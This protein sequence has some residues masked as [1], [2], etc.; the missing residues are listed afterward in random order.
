M[1]GRSCRNSLRIPSTSGRE[2][3]R[4]GAEGQRHSLC[5]FSLGCALAVTR[6]ARSAGSEP[7]AAGRPGAQRRP[8]IPVGNPCPPP[9]LPPASPAPTTRSR[10]AAAAP[11][12]EHSSA[13]ERSGSWRDGSNS[14]GVM[15]R[16]SPARSPASWCPRGGDTRLGDSAPKGRSSWRPR[17]VPTWEL[18]PL[19]W[20]VPRRTVTGRPVGNS[21]FPSPQSTVVQR[22][23]PLRKSCPSR[24]EA[25]AF[26]ALRQGYDALAL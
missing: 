9:R 7:G 11:S 1:G 2:T 15:R 22:P 6:K 8:R 3:R 26:G 19:G 13:P 16:H 17:R 21:L 18:A 10:A 20:L 23:G 25:W 5:Y 14:W 24:R 4:S 12:R